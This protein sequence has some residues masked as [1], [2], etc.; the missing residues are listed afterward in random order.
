MRS[1]ISSAMRFHASA[2]VRAGA[3]SVAGPKA[4]T[5]VDDNEVDADQLQ[6]AH[7]AR[8]TLFLMRSF[9]IA[10]PQCSITITLP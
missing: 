2:L 9:L 1:S 7:V 3:Y 5:A 6:Q 10:W 4:V 8:E